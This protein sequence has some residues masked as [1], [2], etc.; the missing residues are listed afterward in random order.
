M[1]LIARL[2]ALGHGIKWNYLLQFRSKDPKQVFQTMDGF[3]GCFNELG[4]TALQTLPAELIVDASGRGAPT[5]D[6]LE[7]VGLPE[8][9]ETVIGVDINYA[10]ALYDV[11]ADATP[12]FKA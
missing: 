12:D 10:T 9:E 4:W 2:V 11:P 3:G 8:P 5:L 6:F 1:D 7:S